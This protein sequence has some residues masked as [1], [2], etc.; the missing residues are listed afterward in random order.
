MFGIV[1]VELWE[2]NTYMFWGVKHICFGKSL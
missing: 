1:K 2:G